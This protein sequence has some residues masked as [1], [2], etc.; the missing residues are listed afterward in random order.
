M[1][2]RS[3]HSIALLSAIGIAVCPLPLF[4]Q[5]LVH[6]P[7]QNLQAYHWRL[8][9]PFRGGRVL[10]VTGVPQFPN[11]FYFGAVDGGVWESENAGRTWTPIFD[12]ENVGS[13]GAIAVAPSNPDVIYV[14]TGE[15][16]MRSDIGLGDGMYR[17]DDAGKTWRKIGLDDTQAIGKI[18]VDQADP[19]TVY[20][21]A[22]GHP[23][24]ANAQRGVFKSTD[25]GQ[26]WVHVLDRGPDVGAIDLAIDPADSQT[27]FAAAWQTRRPPW[28]VYPPSNGPGSGLF[29]SSDGGKSWNQIK[30]SGFPSDPGRIGIAFAPS[31][32][33]RIFAV[34]D[35]SEGGLYRSDD[36]GVTWSKVSGDGR[37]WGRG[38]YFCGV[39]VNPSDPD[40]VFV[41]NT[42][43]YESKDGGKTFNPIKG[44]PGGDD[45]HTLWIDGQDPSHRILGVD[46]GCVVSVT[47]GES[48]SSWY[49]QPIAQIYQVAADNHFPYWVY[50]AQ[51]D[52]GA[53]S[54][55]S[56]TWS[57][58][59]INMTNFKGITVGGESKMVAPD[60]LNPNIV[61]GGVVD[62]LDL[63]LG[64]TTSVSPA[65]SFPGVYRSTWTLP[66]V[67][68]EADPHRLY[69]SFQNIFETQ[70]G[71][72][73]WRKISPDLT[74]ENPDVPGNLDAIT[75]ADTPIA[76]PRRGV[77]YAI[78][79]SPVAKDLIWAG[80]DDGLVWKTVDD[81]THWVN[82]TPKALTSWSKVSGIAGSHL[83]SQIAYVAVDRH[84][85]NDFKPYLYKTGDGGKSWQ[86]MVTGIPDGDFINAVCE[87][88][89]NPSLV[90]VGTEKGVFSSFDAGHHWQPLKFN[91]PTTSVR[92]VIEK[93]GDLVIATHGRGFYVLTDLDALRGMTTTHQGA[94]VSLFAPLAA[95]EVHAAG[96]VGSPMPKSE[97][98]GENPP[99]GAILDYLVGSGV[100]KVSLEIKKDGKLIA[101]SA[102]A[103]GRSGR[104]FSGFQSDIAP[105]WMQAPIG[106]SNDPGLHRYVWNLRD[107]TGLWVPPGRYEVVLTADGHASSQTLEVKLDPRA[108][109]TPANA[110]SNYKL[111]QSIQKLSAELGGPS[112]QADQIIHGLVSVLNDHFGG[113]TA[114]HPGAESDAERLSR[115]C[116]AQL[117][118]LSDIS[119]INDPRNSVGTPL[120]SGNSFRAISGQLGALQSM[121]EDADGPATPNVL[122]WLK[123]TKSR[124]SEALVHWEVI[125]SSTIPELNRALKQAGIQVIEAHSLKEPYQFPVEDKD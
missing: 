83:G 125:Q 96:F 31:Q 52:S 26:T 108:H 93:N 3:F 7:D 51:Q 114:S 73:S 56:N 103:G 6:V 47:G 66:L 109:L 95:Y 104:R 122:T 53:V 91:L 124:L 35:S 71:A 70:D 74:R 89:V 86:L 87:D 15:A 19:N 42:A 60:P 24:G 63:A 69:A 36:A 55:P 65:A 67:F 72:Q 33:S 18:T 79:P 68:S 22:L 92:S 85:L 23:Y 59:G 49:N 50:G 32:P 29:K 113:L 13:I 61:F 14:G 115:K 10:A 64:L 84:R 76:S 58:D 5:A 111:A 37:I 17:S 45:Y 117:E 82:V 110:E 98:R 75:A 101:S 39:T 77:V 4:G 62:K 46:Q 40:D 57:I 30:G 20:V 16:D 9:G 11:R 81:G 78:A 25:G 27:I 121:I 116:L 21:A 97:P 105:G 48:W 12:Q 102:S 90:F 80:T 94:K 119:L 43:L 88:P 41:C 106:L 107:R 120:S 123:V 54:L 100:K 38:W 1:F 112:G 118:E 34:V 99:E 28:N 8:L 44:A 2:L